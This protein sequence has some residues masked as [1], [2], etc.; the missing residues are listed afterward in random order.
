MDDSNFQ[1]LDTILSRVRRRTKAEVEE[2]KREWAMRYTAAHSDFDDTD[3]DA[4]MLP[5][6]AA[7]S[8]DD[9]RWDDWVEDGEEL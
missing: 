3:E 9:V 5:A 2:E 4:T 8:D 6:V 1:A 7:S